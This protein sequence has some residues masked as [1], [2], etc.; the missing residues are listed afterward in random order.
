MVLGI[1]YLAGE[2]GGSEEESDDGRGEFFH[3]DDEGSSHESGPSVRGFASELE[4]ESSLD[5]G[6]TKNSGSGCSMNEEVVGIN[7]KRMTDSSTIA[8][9]SESESANYSDSALDTTM[10][11][12]EGGES[13]DYPLP[14]ARKQI[15][16]AARENG[17]DDGSTKSSES[18]GSMDEEG[19]GINGNPISGDS[20]LETPS[21]STVGRAFQP[22]NRYVGK[23]GFTGRITVTRSV[24]TRMSRVEHEDN[25]YCHALRRNVKE[26][27][28]MYANR[29]RKRGL[30]VGSHIFYVSSD[31]K[32]KIPIGK[33]GRPI[34]TRVRSHAK[35]RTIAAVK[36]SGRTDAGRSKRGACG[37][38]SSA[39]DH[40]F[41]LGCLAPSVNLW[42]A[43]P[44]KVNT[45]WFQGQVFVNTKDAV[46]RGSNGWRHF[47]QLAK[48][49]LKRASASAR[50]AC[51]SSL[52]AFTELPDDM[53]GRIMAHVPRVGAVS[54]DGGADH[55]NST[56]TNIAATHAFLLFF[57]MALLILFRNAP[58]ASWSNT[59]ERVMSILNLPLQNQSFARD[60]CKTPAI[61]KIVASCGSMAQL[62]EASER[63]EGLQ[64]RKEWAGSL[65]P[66]RRK[67]DDRFQRMQLKGE[68]F[69]AATDECDT[70]DVA[71]L[72]ACL[73]AACS[74]YCPE[75]KTRASLPK[76]PIFSKY[77]KQNGTQLTTYM[78]CV[79]GGPGGVARVPQELK[80]LIRTIPVPW[81]AD[82][83]APHHL[84]LQ[85]TW[86]LIDQGAVISERYRPSSLST[87]R[88]ETTAL[89]K[90]INVAYDRVF[91]FQKNVVA[92]TRCM[93]C[94]R[95]RC[96]Y[97]NEKTGWQ[98][99]MRVCGMSLPT[100]VDHYCDMLPFRCGEELVPTTTSE[101]H[102]LVHC[103][104]SLTC[105]VPVM[106]DYYSQGPKLGYPPV[107]CYCG[108]EGNLATDTEAMPNGALPRPQCHACVADPKKSRIEGGKRVSHSIDALGRPEGE[109][110]PPGPSKD[111]REEL[112]R[113]ERQEGTTPRC[114]SSSL[115][116]RPVQPP[117][118]ATTSRRTSGPE[119][120]TGLPPAASGLGSAIKPQ[121]QVRRNQQGKRTCRCG[122][123]SH[124]RITSKHCPLNKKRRREEKGEAETR[125][126]GILGECSNLRHQQTSLTL[127]HA[128]A[129]PLSSPHRA[130]KVPRTGPDDRLGGLSHSS[131]YQAAGEGPGEG[132]D[133]G[134]SAMES[135]HNLASPPVSPRTKTARANNDI[136]ALE[137]RATITLDQAQQIGSGHMMQ[138]CWSIGSALGIGITRKSIRTL[139]QGLELDGDVIMLYMK[140]VTAG[141]GDVYVF[142]V[143]FWKTISEGATAVTDF[144]ATGLEKKRLLLL[145]IHLLT[146][147]HWTLMTVD[148]A[149]VTI[150]Y[151]DSVA[152]T[153]DKAEEKMRHLVTY[154]NANVQQCKW[155]LKLENPPVQTG[156]NCGA[157]V[158]ATAER[159]A[160]NQAI[161]FTSADMDKPYRIVMGRHIMR[162][163]RKPAQ[164]AVKA[165]A[166]AAVAGEAAAAAAVV[167][168][169]VAAVTAAD[170]AAAAEM[171]TS[172]PQAHA[173]SQMSFYRDGFS[174]RNQ[175]QLHTGT[176][177]AVAAEPSQGEEAAAA[178][179]AQ[180]HYD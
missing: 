18:G 141:M 175:E 146:A 177:V 57:E 58:A 150:S 67:I 61:E 148:I 59:A 66:V 31:D 76:M 133:E 10:D 104:L 102:G 16:A 80:T 109:M 84:R 162:E 26:W 149:K 170:A 45:S 48:Q 42:I 172:Q 131:G 142:D 137:L 167:E 97:A 178:A 161:D 123:Q 99:N 9:G 154:L 125:S 36:P 105:G 121:A 23:C 159:L 4:D 86:S 114:T 87:A 40:G 147:N 78:N 13:D 34:E 29:V 129:S 111:N 107:C 51:P 96:V 103:R 11:H 136:T 56:V 2:E 46:F 179:T 88:T 35:S 173:D 81:K 5:D 180:G 163:L 145:P 44:E 164:A 82:Q 91:N 60:K 64:V 134:G 122:S 70:A 171:K 72:V 165:L 168:V 98:R 52:Q 49:M 69:V 68:Q 6:S 112:P 33:P 1:C 14:F 152:G 124:Q 153:Q 54:T 43:I 12:P 50:V 39:L 126:S 127:D 27:L 156:L 110:V 139:R 158:C 24:Q 74:D 8:S 89:N 79:M 15:S 160:K 101:L 116:R 41:H 113:K 115:Q 176:R 30:P 169:A 155:L 100:A 73:K 37:L 75:N 21:E 3:S 132:P 77:I 143:L 120:C 95:P 108:E 118:V 166:A 130:N 55:N 85:E 22:S 128:F 144:D 94:R 63:E 32:T 28:V 117:K 7:G 90:P 25:H 20:D 106:R 19:A 38:L 174:A 135:E 92:A 157:H 140:S 119:G 71:V 93:N 138:E 17:K 83:N 47:A 62:R 151:W 53:K 65:K